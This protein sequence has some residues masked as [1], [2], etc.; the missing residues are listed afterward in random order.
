MSR[1]CIADAGTSQSMKYEPHGMIGVR[2]KICVDGRK[3]VSCIGLGVT[4][5]LASCTRSMSSLPAGT[6]QAFTV[7]KS[8]RCRW[9]ARAAV[10]IETQCI[11]CSMTARYPKWP[12]IIKLLCYHLNRVATSA[13]PI[14]PPYCLAGPQRRPLS[15]P[16]VKVHPGCRLSSPGL[17]LIHSSQSRTPR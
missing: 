1:S 7:G 11:Y 14:Q 6:D 16:I 15:S 3:G 12:T 10:K 5:L 9:H 8:V 2:Y 13:L 4:K 17:L